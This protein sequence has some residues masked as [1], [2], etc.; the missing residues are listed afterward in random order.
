MHQCKKRGTCGILNDIIEHVILV[1]LMYN[2]E[3]VNHELS[4]SGYWIY[5]YN[6]KRELPMM[7]E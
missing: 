1:Q 7:K 2:V 3:N 6:Y 5:D 4:M